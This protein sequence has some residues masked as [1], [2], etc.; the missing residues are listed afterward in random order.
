MADPE[1]TQQVSETTVGELL[2]FLVQ[3]PQNRPVE[4]VYDGQTTWGPITRYYFDQA[5]G[6]VVLE[7][8]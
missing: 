7:T 8:P 6:R 3:M 5:N 1:T 4:L 2:H